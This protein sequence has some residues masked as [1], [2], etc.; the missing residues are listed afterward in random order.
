M[1][2]WLIGLVSVTFCAASA[3]DAQARPD[4]HGCEGCEAIHERAHDGLPAVVAIAGPG[5]PGT[6]LVLRGRVMHP[7]GRTPAAG[8]VI[9]A[10]HTNAAGAYPPSDAAPWARRHGALRGWVKTDA[11]GTYEFRTVRPGGYPGR[12]DPA[13]VHLV[14]KEPGRR[15]YWID[16]VVFTDDPRVTPHYVA[17]QRRRGGSGVVTPTRARDGSWL[18]RRD[19]ILE[20]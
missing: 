1:R 14:V 11:R 9:Y 3:C 16:D 13:H 4:L 5:E 10:Y 15:E 18:A 12:A 8:V 20:R 6:P 2:A 7:D 19:I 17:T